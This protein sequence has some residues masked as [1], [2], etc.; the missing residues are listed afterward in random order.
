MGQ[1]GQK[2]DKYLKCF[3]NER[4]ICLSFNS[5]G[6]NVRYHQRSTRQVINYDT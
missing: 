2:N 3:Q 6:E 5:Q 4:E 1:L